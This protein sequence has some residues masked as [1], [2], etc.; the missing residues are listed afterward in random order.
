MRSRGG[1]SSESGRPARATPRAS[2]RRPPARRRRVR[3]ATSACATP[4]KGRRCWPSHPI[5]SCRSRCRRLLRP[6]SVGAS[7]SRA[8]PPARSSDSKLRMRFPREV[9]HALRRRRLPFRPADVVLLLDLGTSTLKRDRVFEQSFETVSFAVSAATQLLR[10]PTDRGAAP[11]RARSLGAGHRRPGASADE[12]GGRAATQ[13]PGS[14]GRQCPGW[15][16]RSF[17]SR[18]ARRLGQGG[19]GGPAAPFRELGRRSAP[20]RSLRARL[21]GATDGCVAPRSDRGGGALRELRHAGRGASRAAPTDRSLHLRHSPAARMA[22]RARQRG[23]RQGSDLGDDRD[24]RAVGRPAPRASR[25]PRRS[26]GTARGRHDGSL[27]QSR[28]RCDRGPRSEGNPGRTH[29]APD[30]TRG[31]PPSRPAQADRGDRRRGGTRDARPRRADPSRETTRG[32]AEGRPGLGGPPATR[33]APRAS[34]PRPGPTC[35]RILRRCREDVLARSRRPGRDTALHGACGGADARARN[36]VPIRPAP[37]ASAPSGT[38][39]RA[40]RVGMCDLRGNVHH[41]VRRVAGGRRDGGALVRTLATAL[42]GS[43]LAPRRQVVG[44]GVR[45]RRAR[46]PDAYAP[47]G[48]CRQR[49]RRGVR[50]PQTPRPSGGALPRDARRRASSARSRPPRSRKPGSS[51]WKLT[52]ASDRDGSPGRRDRTWPCRRPSRPDQPPP[53]APQVP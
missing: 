2:A 41:V 34:G 8:R 9:L 10:G 53:G 5:C 36:L 19:R 37:G 14:P 43:P 29:R 4:P 40:L 26:A 46:L 20:R 16:A 15:A 13:D 18:L 45:A 49:A 48:L 3:R 11:W 28:Q 6:S 44:Q 7:N 12:R 17:G 25:A 27:A 32:P 23:D 21:A 33:V 42:R 30:A 47:D 31:D 52:R 24:R 38:D 39:D 50:C 1:S 22:P 35:G 51:A